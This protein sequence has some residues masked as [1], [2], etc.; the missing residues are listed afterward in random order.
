MCVD[1]RESAGV[2]MWLESARVEAAHEE[3]HAHVAV[4]SAMPADDIDCS[5]PSWTSKACAAWSAMRASPASEQ[6]HD[7][8]A[9]L[10]ILNALN[11]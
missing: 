6:L 10:T 2:I 11:E 3:Y 4:C 5:L 9:S 7:G 8:G 1:R